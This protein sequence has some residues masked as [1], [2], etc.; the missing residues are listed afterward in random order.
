M[1]NPKQNWS[2]SASPS[3][4]ATLMVGSVRP[5]LYHCPR[6]H[7]VT[8]TGAMGAVRVHRYEQSN[9]CS[10]SGFFFFVWL[11]DS[12]ISN[13]AKNDI[14][15]LLKKKIQNKKSGGSSSSFPR[16]ITHIPGC[17]QCDF[18]LKYEP[19]NANCGKY[20]TNWEGVCIFPAPVVPGTDPIC[21]DTTINACCCKFATY[22]FMFCA[23]VNN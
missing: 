16:W 20:A 10:F 12:S 17:F 22:L 21:Y 11:F 8:I 18:T 9:L 6:R 4:N 15:K 1:M 3:R 2:P 7:S 14:M 13:K 23:I 19:L 5:D